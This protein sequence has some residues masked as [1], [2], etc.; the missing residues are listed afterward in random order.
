[1][2]VFLRIVRRTLAVKGVRRAVW[3][4]VIQVRVSGLRKDEDWVNLIG[5]SQTAVAIGAQ[6]LSAAGISIK[7]PWPVVNA[8][9]STENPIAFRRPRESDTGKKYVIDR[10]LEICAPVLAAKPHGTKSIGCRICN[11]G[12]EIAQTVSD[13]MPSLLDLVTESKI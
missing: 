5:G 10:V 11:S 8:E 7:A 1:M 9:A 6:S 3:A 12:I 4:N 2:G 13:L